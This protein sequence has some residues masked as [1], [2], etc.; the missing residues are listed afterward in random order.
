[1]K[2]TR[3]SANPRVDSGHE[4]G[5]ALLASHSPRGRR[6]HASTVT[7]DG[8]HTTAM[9]SRA[10]AAPQASTRRPSSWHRRRN[11]RRDSSIVRMLATTLQRLC[12]LLERCKE[13]GLARSLTRES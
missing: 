5:F 7:R 6:S 2:R 1:V 11:A 4:F 3:P 12:R 10:D 9:T 13:H 8:H